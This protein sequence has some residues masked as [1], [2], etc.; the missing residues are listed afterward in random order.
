MKKDNFSKKYGIL[1]LLLV[2]L[3]T[4]SACRQASSSNSEPISEGLAPTKRDKNISFYF[5]KLLE[6][7]H[8]SKHKI[9]DEISERAFGLFLKSIDPMKIYFTR[10][11]IDEFSA[12][13]K[14]RIDDLVKAGDITPAFVIYNRFI[15]RVCE[16]CEMAHQILNEPLDFNIDE[17]YV[18]D[19]DKLD[20]PK[21][22]EEVRDRLRKKIK[23]E[24]LSLE[25]DDRD[26]KKESDKE[27]SKTDKDKADKAE[28]AE[29]TTP[30]DPPLVRINRRYNSL[31]KRIK[32]TTND[33]VLECYLT[34]IANSFDPHSSYMSPK[35]FENFVIQMRLNLDGIGATLGW[36]DGYTVVKSIVKGGAADKQ[37]ELKVEDRIISV[38]QDKGPFEDVVDMG[39]T[40][41]VSKIRGKRGTTVRLEVLPASKKGK[42]IITIVREKIELEDSAAQSKVFEV[43][44]KADGSPYKVGVIDLPSFYFDMDARSRGDNSGRSTTR[45]VRKLLQNFVAEKVD[46]CVI[47][48]RFNG[49]G[50]LQEV[51]DLTGLFI[52]TG[53]VVQ[54]APSEYGPR[55]AKSLED[56]DPGIEWGGPLVV[57]TSKFSASASEIFAGAIKDYKRGIIVGDHTTHGKGTV[58]PLIE[59]GELLFGILSEK[60]NYGT[61]KVS[62]QG[63]YLPHGESTQLL[64][65]QSDVVLPSLTDVMDGSEADSDY[66]LRF[67]KI[68]PAVDYPT[69]NYVS[70]EIIRMLNEKSAERIAKS[71]DFKRVEKNVKVYKEIKDEKKTPLKREKYFAELDRLDMDKH[72]KKEYEKLMGMDQKI[73]RDYYMNEVLDI[74]S[75]Y[76]EI[77]KANRIEFAKEKS[78][79]FGVSSFFDR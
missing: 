58:Q 57:V 79:G 19:K 47:D 68:A 49:G 77:L 23:F 76:L 55:K 4:F 60:A 67:D 39:L 37:G 52:E 1:T 15:Q 56:R 51:V 31:Q 10:Q 26:S 17:Y 73:I 40:D 41:V 16:R 13:Y 38:A 7:R 20:Y 44:K 78:G 22:E 64:G 11:D 5:G 12:E 2:F 70:P 24:L 28:K 53:T 14:D 32:Q 27:D 6:L 61:L 54:V 74:T 3:L 25:A 66:P 59:I 33:D 48:L 75:D 50:S 46:A 30:T 35:T 9:D 18:R 69:F 65:V 72:E 36:E 45:D 62:I 71:D 21:S 34:A 8:V 29:S 43:G 42:K 63:F